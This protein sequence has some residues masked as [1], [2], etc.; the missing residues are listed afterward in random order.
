MD[1]VVLLGVRPSGVQY[2][3]SSPEGAITKGERFGMRASSEWV[4]S[5]VVSQKVSRRS[6]HRTHLARVSRLDQVIVLQQSPVDGRVSRG[7]DLKA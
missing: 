2:P 7:S 5:V 6:S 3:N 4:N 1:L